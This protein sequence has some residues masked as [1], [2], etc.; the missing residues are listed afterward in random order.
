MLHCA[1]KQTSNL[2]Q[3]RIKN[4]LLTYRQYQIGFILY[5]WYALKENAY[6]VH[7]CRQNCSSHSCK[8]QSYIGYAHPLI[9]R[10]YITR[11]ISMSSWGCFQWSCN[12]RAST[13]TFKIQNN[14]FRSSWGMFS[15]FSCNS[16]QIPKSKVTKNSLRL[17]N[18]LSY[19]GVGI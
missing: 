6:Q 12:V 15:I 7:I 17:Q 11:H 4:T 16:I 19:W 13:C 2:K 1:W 3:Q 10:V 14:L 18:K 9:L 5:T 8:V